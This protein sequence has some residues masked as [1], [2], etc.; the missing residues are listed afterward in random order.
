VVPEPGAP[1][2]KMGF[3]GLTRKKGGGSTCLFAC[4][5][6]A[7]RSLS[8][9]VCV[10][11]NLFYYGRKQ[12]PCEA[13]NAAADADKPLSQPGAA[14]ACCCGIV[15]TASTIT[16]P[17]NATAATKAIATERKIITLRQLCILIRLSLPSVSSL[18]K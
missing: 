3:I 17:N 14:S 7:N 6:R 16:I 11:F 9:C 13:L 15:T 12:R 8:L 18:S 2:I 1:T 5:C 4:V 10:C